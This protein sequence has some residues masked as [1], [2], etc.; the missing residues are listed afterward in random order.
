MCVCQGEGFSSPGRWGRGWQAGGKVSSLPGAKDT[1][2]GPGEEGVRPIRCFPP[3]GAIGPS[4]PSGRHL[5]R[6]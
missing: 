6:R 5:N 4:A 1:Q 2:L 3:E